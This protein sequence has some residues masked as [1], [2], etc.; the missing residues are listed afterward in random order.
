MGQWSLR[1]RKGE[2]SGETSVPFVAIEPDQ[3]QPIESEEVSITGLGF[4]D[5]DFADDFQDEKQSSRSTSPLMQRARSIDIDSEQL[6]R[7]EQDTLFQLLLT[8]V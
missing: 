1:H 6:D 5:D 3:A 7:S 2:R 4:G 8:R